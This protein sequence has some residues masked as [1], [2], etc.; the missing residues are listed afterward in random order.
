MALLFNQNNL[1]VASDAKDAVC[2]H[3]RPHFPQTDSDATTMVAE[4]YRDEDVGAVVA[5]AH[6]HLLRDVHPP[7][8]LSRRGGHQG[9]WDYLRPQA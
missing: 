8:C 2:L 7:S 6:P 5:T 3:R 9:T 4:T 1:D